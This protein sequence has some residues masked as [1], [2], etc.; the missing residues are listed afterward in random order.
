MGLWAGIPQ[1][2]RIALALCVTAAVM[3]GF[4]RE[5]RSNKKDN[6]SE[7][8]WD[9]FMESGVSM[10][11]GMTLAALLTVGLVALFLAG[12][13]GFI[14]VAFYSLVSGFL[15]GIAGGLG[16]ALTWALMVTKKENLISRGFE[17]MPK[18][19]VEQKQREQKRGPS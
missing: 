7:S 18:N 11:W 9:A 3:Y 6:G 12:P 17:V 4:L 5:R 16:G 2:L 19:D 15:C 14:A 1:W 8:A 10:W 13:L